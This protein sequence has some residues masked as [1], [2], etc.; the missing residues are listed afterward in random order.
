MHVL[1]TGATGFIGASLARHLQRHG[2][3]VFA[4]TRNESRGIDGCKMVVWDM[5]KSATPPS[6]PSGIDAI[7]HTAQSRH[8]RAFPDDC[9][10]MFDVNVAATHTLLNC[11][12]ETGVKRFCLLSS[13]S[14]Y[15]PFGHP[16]EEESALAPLGFLGASKYA[17]EVLARPYA[18]SLS[19]SVLRLFFPYGP[20]QA[21]RLIPN[22]IRCV[23]TGSPIHVSMDG[24]GLRLT[25][26]FV[27]DIV[28]VISSAVAE[29]W[30]GTF[31]VASPEPFSIAG[32]SEAIGLVVG[33]APVLE[34][35]PQL[36]T[37]IIPSI[38]KLQK[39]FDISTFM[40]L[41]EG[42]QRTAVGL[43]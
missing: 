20:G 16:L 19:L 39:Q 28:R 41:R 10:E 38:D 30:V 12:A 35:T 42:L 9:Q 7:V 15:E 32:I 14:V 31:N 43:V 17:A 4:M 5:E 37:N 25:P 24:E 8:Y 21:D 40:S 29:G 2:H 36:V 3:T 27:D 33:K 26:T 22:L 6:L 23:R 18:K 11:A 13:G 34:V 1:V